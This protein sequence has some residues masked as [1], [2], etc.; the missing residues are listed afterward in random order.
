M[1][2]LGIDIGGTSVK[3]G[4]VTE[5]GEILYSDNFNVS[6]DNYETPIFETVKKSI[7]IFLE[8]NSIEKDEFQGIGVSATGQINTKT[9]TVVGVGGN[10]RKWCGTEIKN[11]LEKIYKVKTTVINDANS[12]TIGEQWIGKGKDYRNIIGITIGTGVGGGI[13]VDSNILLGNIGIAGEI[14]H[15]SIN[16]KGKLCT[17]GNRGCYEQYAS[18]TGLIKEVKRNYD[19]IDNFNYNK[20]EIN[21][22]II[23]DEIEKGNEK[24]ELIVKEWIAN[25]GSGLISLVHIFNPEIIIV[26]G[27]VSKQEKLFIDPLRKYVTNKVMKRFGEK[28]KIEGAELENKAGLVGAVYYNIKN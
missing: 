5:K 26:G 4:L 7:E 15:F 28:L 1:K 8:K 10:I 20:D 12:M 6:F 22:K 14:G 25:I 16:S 23:F 13:I 27:A 17:C 3:I 9:G 19:Y 2:Y 18:M 21:G 24:L 11:E